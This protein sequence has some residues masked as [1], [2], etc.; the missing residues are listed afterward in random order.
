MFEL[1]SCWH[2][3]SLWNFQ[4]LKTVYFLNCCFVNFE[5]FNY[6]LVEYVKLWNIDFWKAILAPVP[7]P[8]PAWTQGVSNP[9]PTPYPTLHL[10]C[11]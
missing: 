11:E 7:Q 6:W 4:S 1:L 10:G 2:S 5:T 8:L 9:N 3:Q